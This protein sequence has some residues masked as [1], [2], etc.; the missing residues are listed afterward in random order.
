MDLT[1]S[2]LFIGNADVDHALVAVTRIAAGLIAISVTVISSAT[3]AGTVK[4]CIITVRSRVSS[5]ASA[6][7]AAGAAYI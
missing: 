4:S 7:F 2:L 5:F 6:F 3:A 1:E